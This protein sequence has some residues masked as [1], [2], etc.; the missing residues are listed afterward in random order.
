[1]SFARLLPWLPVLLLIAMM[2]MSRVR[3]LAMYRR[4]I[5]AII[6]DWHRPRKEIAYDTLII[7]VFLLWFYLLVA[8]AWPLSLAWLPEALTYKLVNSL[9]A[10]LVGAALLAAAPI[11]FAAALYSM[12]TSWRIGIDRIQP[13]PLVTT[14]LFAYMRNPIYVAF[15]MLLVGVFLFHGRGVFLILA[16]VLGLLVH[17]VILREERFLARQYGDSFVEYCRRVGRY[18]PRF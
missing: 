1:M 11:V 2:T 18:G 3:A 4:G 13:G 7:V 6:V 17:G 9:P 8:E 14:G 10:K 16:A 5:R 12:S 15:D